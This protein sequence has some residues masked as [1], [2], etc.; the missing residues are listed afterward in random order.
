MR[1]DGSVVLVTGASRGIGRSVASLA[2]AGGARVVALARSRVDLEKLSAEV[3]QDTLFPVVVDVRDYGAL[4]QAISF[5]ER[6]VGPVDVVVANAGVGAFGPFAEMSWSEVQ[7][8]V[9][10]NVLGTMAVLRQVTPR[11]IERGRG[12]VC[13]VGSVAGRIGVP[14]EAAYSAT[15]FAT[16]GL[17][18]ALRA[19]LGPHGCGVSLVSLGPVDTAFYEARGAAYDRRWPR[20]LSEERAAAAVLSAVVHERA[21]VFLPRWLRSAVLARQLLPV[22][23]RSGTWRISLSRRAAWA[24]SR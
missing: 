2:A 24:T 14:L 21:E 17:A 23:V 8:L 11:M 15:K 20:L 10:V 3:G 1:L 16:A 9:E 13:V 5:A 12:H 19:E 6:E 18:E 4:G 22:L 7:R